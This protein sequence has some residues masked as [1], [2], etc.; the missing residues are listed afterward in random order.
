M[1]TL[2]SKALA[3]AQSSGT[4][5][6]CF[7]APGQAFPIQVGDILSGSSTSR[8][9]TMS[10]VED[11]KVLDEDGSADAVPFWLRS[12]IVGL[13]VLGVS[14]EVVNWAAMVGC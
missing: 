10:V 2:D 9:T 6:L 14:K 7:W 3:Q 8:A 12:W 11:W 1:F 4:S 5:R 13:V